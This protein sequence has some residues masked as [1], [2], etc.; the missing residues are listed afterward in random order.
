MIY[1]MKKEHLNEKHL[2]EDLTSNLYH[3]WNDKLE[4]LT[5]ICDYYSYTFRFF[6]YGRLVLQ[7]MNN[8]TKDDD[9]RWRGKDDC[10]HLEYPS[11]DVMLIDWLDELK[12]NEGSYKFEEEIK[13]IMDLQ[14]GTKK[15]VDYDIL[16]ELESNIYHEW[17]DKLE[18]LTRICDYYS[19]TFRFFSYGR[20]VLQ[21]MN[22]NTKDDDSRWRGKD[23]CGHLEYP[24]IDV[25]LIDWLDE[26]KK[27][28]GSYKFEE[29]IK[30]IKD[31]QES[32]KRVVD[33]D[34]LK[35]LEDIRIRM[36][37][38]N[39]DQDRIILSD[40]IELIKDHEKYR[41]G[42]KVIYE[43]TDEND[44]ILCPNCR[45]SVARMDDYEEMRPAHCPECG[46]KLIYGAENPT[47][48]TD[49]EYLQE[50]DSGIV[51]AELLSFLD[52]AVYNQN[53]PFKEQF[54]EFI[55]NDEI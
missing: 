14:E 2:I 9:S 22:N 16:K 37:N 39:F 18:I 49:M 53:R 51:K 42:M 40:A 44:D 24:S 23:D 46:T 55:K 8:N 4:I 17:N 29:E 32:N 35:E 10:G 15:V 41:T 31:L 20:L 25:M 50:L 1:T 13:F 5:R 45:T 28:E 47:E 11:I 38:T 48:K 19:Y 3:E 30:F 34:I 43:G 36:Y 52:D 27:N 54:V 26:L 21:I 33:Y 6:S 12:K 7:I